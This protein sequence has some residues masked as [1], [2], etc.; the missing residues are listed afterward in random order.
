MS[1][2]LLHIFAAFAELEWEMIGEGVIAGI[3][4]AR[5]NGPDKWRAWVVKVGQAGRAGLHRLADESGCE[6]K[7][8]QFAGERDRIR[9]QASQRALDLIRRRLLAGSEAK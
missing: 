8:R 4:T 9:W 6:V 7:E 1:R 2:F 3:R 5:I